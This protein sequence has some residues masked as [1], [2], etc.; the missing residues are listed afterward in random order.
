MYGG[1]GHQE[2]SPESAIIPMYVA[3]AS[4]KG[5][6]GKTMISTSLALCADQCTYADLDVE[7]PNGCLFLKPTITSFESFKQLIPEIDKRACTLCG[8]C[9][10]ACIYNA[11][12]VIPQMKDVLFFE[13]LCHSCGVCTYVCPVIGAIR[14]VDKVIGK[15]RIG[16]AGKIKFIEGKLNVGQPSGVPLIGG[17]V[18]RYLKGEDLYIVDVSPGTSCPVVESIKGSDYVIL[19]TEPTPFG[20]SDLK[21]TVELVKDLKLK[22]GI[23]INKDTGTSDIIDRFA[24]EVHLPV[25]Q[26]IPYSLDMQKAYSRGVPL[27]QHKP[28]LIPQFKKV[29]QEIMKDE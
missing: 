13:D 17:L 22:A 16:E 27:V 8:K 24:S 7:E 23:I 4:G 21:L 26:R 25:L 14:E 5:G 3:I 11:L 2:L 18:Q 28:Q 20:L 10:E 15:I 12:M 6:T 9:S 19:V 29:L 1:R